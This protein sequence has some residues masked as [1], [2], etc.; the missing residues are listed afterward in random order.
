M[1]EKL[2]H[3][4]YEPSEAAYRLIVEL[5][6]SGEYNRINTSSTSSAIIKTFDELKTHF[7][8][9]KKDLNFDDIN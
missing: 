2:P 3:P 8:K 6:R 4:E 9:N 1:S 7:E 5:I